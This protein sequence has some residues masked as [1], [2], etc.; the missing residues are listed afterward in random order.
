MMTVDDQTTGRSITKIRSS[1]EARKVINEL[2]TRRKSNTKIVKE[3]NLNHDEGSRDKRRNNQSREADKIPKRSNSFSLPKTEDVAAVGGNA[4]PRNPRA[5]GAGGRK[6]SGRRLISTASTPRRTKSETNLNQPLPELDAYQRHASMT[7]LVSLHPQPTTPRHS[8]SNLDK[9][10]TDAGAKHAANAKSPGYYSRKMQ[11]QPEQHLA[12][13]HNRPNKEKP[14]PAQRFIDAKLKSR[15]ENCLLQS[16][17]RRKQPS[18]AN[19]KHGGNSLTPRSP[20]VGRRYET[21]EKSRPVTDAV[22]A[23]FEPPRTKVVR[24]RSFDMT[25]PGYDARYE[26]QIEVPQL[27]DVD[28]EIEDECKKKSVDKCRRWMNRYMNYE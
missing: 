9:N 22:D 27:D 19:A 2:L 6:V 28:K 15:S 13:M 26:Q 7:Q 1:D 21:R 12:S 3:V 24:E 4:S 16:G 17:K 25:F 14:S 23:S 8:S 18:G 20:A 5:V 11:D 10:N